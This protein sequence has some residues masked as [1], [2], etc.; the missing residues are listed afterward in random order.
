MCLV[1]LKLQFADSY[2]RGSHSL[3]AEIFGHFTSGEFSHVANLLVC[4]RPIPQS[5]SSFALCS[6]KA[7][8][9]KPYLHLLFQSPHA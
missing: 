2:T 7:Q 5:W 9:L 8:R 3:L 6:L 4:L 1:E